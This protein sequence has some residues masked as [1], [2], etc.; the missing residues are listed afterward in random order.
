MFKKA[1]AVF[2]Q[3]ELETLGEQMEAVKKAAAR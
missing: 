3:T 2:E 1:R